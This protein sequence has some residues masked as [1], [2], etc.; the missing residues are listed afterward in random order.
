MT[1][2]PHHSED[3]ALKPTAMG[4]R[5]CGAEMRHG[6]AMGQT[7]VARRESRGDDD[8]RTF[9]AGGTGRVV[10]CLKCSACG[11]SVTP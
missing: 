10:A 4:C 7:V 3:T 8:C 5:R 2:Q 1:Y 9:H 11:W 6:V